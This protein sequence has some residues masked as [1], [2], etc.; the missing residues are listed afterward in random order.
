MATAQSISAPKN[1]FISYRRAD[2]GGETGRLVDHLQQVFDKDQIFMD[3]ENLEPG[4]DFTEAL[5]K[6]LK[7]C[8]VLLAIIGRQWLGETNGGGQNRLQQEGDWVRKEIE[9]AIKRNIRVIPVLVDDGKMPDKADLPEGLHPLLNRQAHIINHASFRADTERLID[10][11]KKIGVEEKNVAPV[12]TKTSA[13]MPWVKIIGGILILGLI[14]F[15]VWQWLLKPVDPPV[16]PGKTNVADSPQIVNTPTVPETTVTKPDK[17][18]ELLPLG[19]IYAKPFTGLWNDSAGKFTVYISLS[20]DSLLL[21]RKNNDKA[22]WKGVGRVNSSRTMKFTMQSGD[23]KIV[24]GSATMPDSNTI[25]G[26]MTMPLAQF[27]IARPF[28]W[29]RVKLIPVNRK[30]P[31]KAVTTNAQ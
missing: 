24:P 31:Q 18:I 14:A 26:S 25:K 1:I 7:K 9:T 5:T 17:P 23:G 22:E 2:T 16:D 6:N 30:L 13:G 19:A 10:L 8:H 28:V 29:K 12:T 3:V 15:A 11:L 20:G 21:T 4:M 27:K